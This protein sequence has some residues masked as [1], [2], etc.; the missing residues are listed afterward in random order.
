MTVMYTFKIYKDVLREIDLI[1]DQ[2]FYTKQEL[3]KWF[4]V[5]I[6]TGKGIPLD[7][8]LSHKFRANAALNQANKNLKYI[9]RLNSRLYMLNNRRDHWETIIRS[10]EGLDYKIA[11]Y[12]IVHD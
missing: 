11:Y 1:Q 4:G 7:G 12:R 10:L 5:D 2:L 6:D 8:Y 9:H 3:K